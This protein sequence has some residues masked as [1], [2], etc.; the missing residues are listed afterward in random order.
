VARDESGI[1]LV[2]LPPVAYIF[3]EGQPS[4][5]V[6]ATLEL[7]GMRMELRCVDQSHKDHGQIVNLKW[8][9]A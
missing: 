2:N 3:R 4:G 1:H 5:W 7:D 8:R 9:E 6:R